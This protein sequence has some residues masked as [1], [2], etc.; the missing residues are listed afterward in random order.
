MKKF[1]DTLLDS[2]FI[3]F[4]L[5]IVLIAAVSI[6]L[7]SAVTFNLF[8]L[9]GGTICTFILFFIYIFIAVWFLD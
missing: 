7:G 5:A 2:L 6:V 9:V 3:V 1:V 8:G 4:W